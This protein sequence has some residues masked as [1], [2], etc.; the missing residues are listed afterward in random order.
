[1]AQQHLFHFYADCLRIMSA[2]EGERGGARYRTTFK[3]R[4]LLQWGNLQ[5]LRTGLIIAVQV[6]PSLLLGPM[7]SGYQ[8]ILFPAIRL[9][10]DS[11]HSAG[12]VLY[13]PALLIPIR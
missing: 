10:S 6:S 7:N 3:H 4:L 2:T 13:N 8:P 12:Q 9:I 1:M 5:Q 11:V